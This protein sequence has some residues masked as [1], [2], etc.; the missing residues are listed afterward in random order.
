[1]LR[2]AVE[3]TLCDFEKRHGVRIT[4]VYNGCGVLVTQM[5]AG[6]PPDAYFACDT[7]FV[8]PVADLFLDPVT[9]S[10]NDVVLGVPRGNPKQIRKLDDLARPGLRVGV[11]H[12]AQSALGVLTDRL[13]KQERL[14][15]T[16][17]ANV[18]VESP[19]GDLLINQLRTGS[20]DAIVA[21]RSNV[22][23][24]G[25]LEAVSLDL[26]GARAEQPF[27]VSRTCRYPQLTRQLLEAIRSA[28]SRE[29]FEAAGFHWVAE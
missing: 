13:L 27:V 17:R 9:V 14:D 12:P 16:V 19:T 20:L 7:C 11:G 4:R 29:R 1:M 28:E 15:E 22:Q 2:P 26:P 21:Y 5:K 25:E 24:G 23:T 3:Q 10:R 8:P 6:G 18:K